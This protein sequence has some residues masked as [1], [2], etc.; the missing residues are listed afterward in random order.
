MDLAA[1]L[2]EGVELAP[3]E[4]GSAA[5]DLEALTQLERDLDEVDAA[6]ARLDEGTYGIDA[7][8]GDPIDD[9]R[10]AEDPTRRS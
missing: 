9:A 7:V 6:I 10:L 5:V 1:F 3:A 2:P 8:T 4:T